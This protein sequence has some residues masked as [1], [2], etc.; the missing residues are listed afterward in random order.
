MISFIV[1]LR[2]TQDDMVSG[3]LAIHGIDPIPGIPVTNGTIPP[4]VGSH[5]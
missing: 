1:P 2:V 4:P 5:A 3:D